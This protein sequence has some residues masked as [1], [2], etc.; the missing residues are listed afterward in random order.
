MLPNPPPDLSQLP[1]SV[2]DLRVKLPNIQ[3]S[4][5]PEEFH[6]IDGFQK[7]ANYMAA[8]MI[9]L[10]KNPLL[11]TP[12]QIDDLKPRLLGKSTLL[13]CLFRVWT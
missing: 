1:E 3:S 10:R 13:F 12:L 2:L 11:K 4:L 7:V 6:A 5:T 8:A 9:Y